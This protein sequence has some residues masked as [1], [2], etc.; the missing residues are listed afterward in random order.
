[1]PARATS[2]TTSPGAGS[3]SGSSASS[4]TSGPPNSLIWIALTGDSLPGE[5]RRRSGARQRADL[6]EHRG[7]R[8]RLPLGHLIGDHVLDR[9][10]ER[11]VREGLGEVAQVIAGHGVELLRVEAER[12]RPRQ[13]VGAG[14]GRAAALADL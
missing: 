7:R 4:M 10:D 6:A 8:A 14:L 9:V 2:T 13:Q 12:A 5:R 3:G 1:M 11:Q